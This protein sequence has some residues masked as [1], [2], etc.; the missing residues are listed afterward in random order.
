[1]YT[2]T[3][4]NDTT[5][6]WFDSASEREKAFARRYCHSTDKTICDDLI[7]AASQSVADLAIVP[8][9]DV[10][11]LGTDARMN[12]PSKALGNWNWRF[13]WDQVQPE[14]ALKMYEIAALTSRTKPDRLILPPIPA[15]RR[16]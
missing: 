3:H 1:V 14:H 6:G 13:S 2:G 9:Q 8:F 5:R 16:G 15:G 7:H 10:L 4:D 12:F 11:G